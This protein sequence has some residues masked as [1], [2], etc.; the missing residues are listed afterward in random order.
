[1]GV[2]K[3]GIT[4]LIFGHNK[5]MMRVNQARK[6]GPDEGPKALSDIFF[7]SILHTSRAEPFVASTMEKIHHKIGSPIG[8]FSH[9]LQHAA[10]T[11]VDSK[12]VS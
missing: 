12:M 7:Q 10:S 11:G 8:T 4:F 1:M 3:T 6:V 2:I 5:C 9:D